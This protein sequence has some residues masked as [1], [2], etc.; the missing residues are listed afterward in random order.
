MPAT[1]T[2]DDDLAG[3]LDAAAGVR[4]QP[5]SD[6]AAAI[7]RRALCRPPVQPAA[8]PF[9][10]EPHGGRFAPGIDIQKLNRLAGGSKLES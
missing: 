1:L 2:I 3:L 8:R 6:V 5:R 4:G 9:R 10:V 7:I